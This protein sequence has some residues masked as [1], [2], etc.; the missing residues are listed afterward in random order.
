MTSL[1]GGQNNASGRICWYRKFTLGKAAVIL[2]NKAVIEIKIKA[3]DRNASLIGQDFDIDLYGK[4]RFY[5]EKD[6]AEDPLFSWVSD[7]LL[8]IYNLFDIIESNVQEALQRRLSN[9]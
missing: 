4:A 9:L 2:K 1:I 8:G 7:D 5:G 6:N 3:N